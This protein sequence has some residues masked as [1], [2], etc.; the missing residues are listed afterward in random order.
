M[1]DPVAAAGDG[2][3]Q[4]S[5]FLDTCENLL[6]RSIANRMNCQ[7]VSELV[8]MRE[9]AMHLRIGVAEDAPVLRVADD[10]RLAHGRSQS[11]GAAI[12]EDFHGP[13]AQ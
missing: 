6:D 2:L 12:A 3:L 1:L 10:I 5:G 11:A 13:I 8:V 7:L 4:R 9:I